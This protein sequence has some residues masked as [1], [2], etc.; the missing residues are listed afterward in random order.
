MKTKKAYT[1]VGVADEDDEHGT[2]QGRH[3]GDGASYSHLI[4]VS[5]EQ[6]NTTRAPNGSGR[7]WSGAY[8]GL[9]D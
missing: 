9:R 2:L 5:V 1:N 8:P 6:K 4:I 3:I 7:K